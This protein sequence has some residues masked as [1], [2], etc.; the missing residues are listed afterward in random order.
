[1]FLSAEATHLTAPVVLVGFGD[2]LRCV[3]FSF[4]WSKHQHPSCPQMPFR[5]QLDASRD[6]AKTRADCDAPCFDQLKATHLRASTKQQALLDVLLKL[7]KTW[8]LTIGPWFTCDLKLN[9]PR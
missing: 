6:M 2:A 8:P 3:T 4:S 9:I 5:I 1:M 7:I